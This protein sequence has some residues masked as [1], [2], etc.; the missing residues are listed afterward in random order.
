[1]ANNELE[2]ILQNSAKQEIERIGKEPWIS[3]S[4]GHSSRENLELPFCA[5]IPID[6]EPKIKSY[7]SWDFS[8]G[9]GLPGCIIFSGDEGQNIDYLRFGNDEGIE[10]L[11]IYREFHGMR[12]DYVEVSEEFRLFHSLYFDRKTNKYI[13]FDAYGNEEE[14]VIYFDDVIKIRTKHIRQFLAIKEMILAVYFDVIKWMDK[15]LREL[16]ISETEQ[17]V[18]LDDTVYDFAIRDAAGLS[19][20]PTFSRL[21]G[22][23]VIR[24]YSKE[25][26]GIW[27]YSDE[28]QKKFEDFIVA[29]DKDDEPIMHTCDPDLLSN[30]FGANPGAPHYLTPV[31]FKR[32]VLNKYYSNS[33]KYTVDDNLLRCGSLWSM[34]MDNNHA[35]YVIVYLGDL[36][37]SLSYEEQLYWKSYNV[38]PEGT[39]SRTEFRRAF[40]A[41]PT[42]PERAD[43]LLKS[44]YGQFC[45]R[46]YRCKGWHLFKPLSEQDSHVLR[47]I[48]VPL[49]DDF[50][51]FDVQV[52]NLS[53]LIVDSINNRELK[54]HIPNLEAGTKS[55]SKLEMYL[56]EREVDGFE[57]HIQFLRKLYQ[58]R[59][60]GAGHRKGSDYLEKANELILGNRKLAEVTVE[61]FISAIGL[62]EF[63][64]QKLLEDCEEV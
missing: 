50:A 32:E 12:P 16:G 29:V 28:Q 60:I 4:T 58:L 38:K 14:S 10:P 8:I 49:S 27:P 3:F 39:I 51:E 42:E 25:K 43:L 24:G 31:F 21:L 62:L 41:E 9:S 37:R 19:V 20:Q 11:L 47:T 64:S 48:R 17:K 35:E 46:W 30:Y 54:R 56:R 53:K 1:M 22:K 57:E 2:E 18:R 52:L 26:S 34:W 15:S 6:R 44:V 36:G 7:A 61:L 33:Q 59:S 55:I 23:K 63:L 13:K 5:L 45:R 40:L